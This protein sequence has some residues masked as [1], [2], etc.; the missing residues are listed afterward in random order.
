LA[1]NYLK[2][3]WKIHEHQRK[4]FFFNQLSFTH[5]SSTK[6]QSID[7]EV[8]EFMRT[9]V[10]SPSVRNNTL[11][12]IASDHGNHI[13]RSKLQPTELARLMDQRNPFVY[14]LG[15]RWVLSLDYGYE[16]GQVFFSKQVL[17]GL[18]P[19]SSCP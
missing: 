3:L 13:S 5:D 15:P 2:S 1:Q 19:I 6:V 11:V 9:W 16:D 18:N 7:S 17:T 12:I 14:L 10:N 4:A 8:A